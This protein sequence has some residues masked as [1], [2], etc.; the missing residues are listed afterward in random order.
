MFAQCTFFAKVI[1]QYATFLIAVQYYFDE[2][3]IACAPPKITTRLWRSFSKLTSQLLL[4]HLDQLVY[5]YIQSTGLQAAYCNDLMIVY[6][7]SILILRYYWHLCLW[8]QIHGIF[9]LL[10]NDT[11]QD[12]LRIF[13]NF[14]E[15]YVFGVPDWDRRLPSYPPV[16]WNQY[17]IV[18]IMVCIRLIMW[19]SSSILANVNLTFTLL[20]LNSKSYKLVQRHGSQNWV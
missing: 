1:V 18:L 20:L 12:L 7:K 17:K 13:D 16:I 3:R 2:Y 8:R 15:Y 6:W 10:E 11:P 4:F 9:L 5:R 19:A 14:E